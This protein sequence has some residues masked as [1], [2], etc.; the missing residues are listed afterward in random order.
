MNYIEKMSLQ[1][2]RFSIN[3][4]VIAFNS[5]EWSV[6]GDLAEG[7]D[8][9]FQEAIVLNSRQKDGVWLVDVKFDSGLVSNGHFQS[10]IKR[11]V[12]KVLVS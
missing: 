3:D 10:T 11:A 9:Y 1:K 7:N 8:K 4:R 6:T 5:V 2:T 12:S